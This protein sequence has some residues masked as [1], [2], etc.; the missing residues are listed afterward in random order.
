MPTNS[1]DAASI[2]GAELNFDED[3]LRRIRERVLHAEKE[4]LNLDL[5][6]GINDEIEQIVR[7]EIN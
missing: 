3:S 4:K 6:H 2:E 5:A 1:G 7:E